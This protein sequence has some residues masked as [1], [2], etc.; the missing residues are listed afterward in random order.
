MM[1]I[2]IARAII[3]VVSAETGTGVGTG[4]GVR[5]VSFSVWTLAV[6]VGVVEAA[7]WAASEACKV[8]TR[9]VTATRT[10]IVM[11]GERGM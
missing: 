6:D 7:A 11:I 9:K 2:T 8:P 5:S 1:T 10:R 3:P 4:V